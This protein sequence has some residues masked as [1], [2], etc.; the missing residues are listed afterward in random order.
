MAAA[1]T[2][3][4]RKPSR[5]NVIVQIV[6][7]YGFVLVL[8]SNPSA[9]IVEN[10]STVLPIGSIIVSF[11]VL[12]DPPERVLKWLITSR[13][14]WGDRAA[15]RGS[16]FNQIANE[17]E[18][19]SEARLEQLFIARMGL[20]YDSPYLSRMKAKIVSQSYLVFGLVVFAGVSIFSPLPLFNAPAVAVFAGSMAG[21]IILFISS[22]LDVRRL[23][24]LLGIVGIFELMILQKRVDAS[25]IDELKSLMELESWSEV[26]ATIT[27]FLLGMWLPHDTKA[28]GQ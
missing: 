15:W 26:Q 19:G 2:L 16:V 13:K 14:P 4:G 17:V 10:L 1:A 8:G 27:R 11:L 5:L 3:T 23:F 28:A 21:A 12:A 18:R 20:T 25:Q 7:G 6:F 9:D 24:D 22:L